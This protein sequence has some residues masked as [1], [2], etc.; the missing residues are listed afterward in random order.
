MRFCSTFVLHLTPCHPSFPIQHG[1]SRVCPQFLRSLTCDHRA[2][3]HAPQTAREALRHRF[4]DRW[5]RSRTVCG[6]HTRTRHTPSSSL[7][8]TGIY[9]VPAAQAV[10]RTVLF[11]RAAPPDGFVCLRHTHACTSHTPSSSL[12]AKGTPCP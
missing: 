6:P 2:A 11:A 1:I 4:V 12:F 9:V 5:V 3:R 10:G 7:F 8:V